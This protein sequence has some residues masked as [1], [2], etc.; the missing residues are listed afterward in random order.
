[1]TNTQTLIGK[2][3]IDRMRH[4]LSDQD[5]ADLQADLDS[6]SIEATDCWDMWTDLSEINQPELWEAGESGDAVRAIAIL[7]AHYTVSTL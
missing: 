7:S 1:M 3:V 2:F 6:G 5:V 4:T